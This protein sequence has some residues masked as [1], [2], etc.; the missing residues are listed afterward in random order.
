MTRP[1]DDA[2]PRIPGQHDPCLTIREYMAAQCLAGL[3]A[4][5]THL[6]ALPFELGKA[7]VEYADGLILA[8]NRKGD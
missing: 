1:D 5:D 6:K 8:L 7:A 3:L 2:F 4:S